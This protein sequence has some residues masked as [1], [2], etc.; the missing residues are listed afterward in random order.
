MMEQKIDYK[1]FYCSYLDDINHKLTDSNELRFGKKGSLSIN[2][3][4]GIWFDHQ[5]GEGGNPY[6]FLTQKQ[7]HTKQEALSLLNDDYKTFGHKP[8]KVLKQRGST[9]KQP[10]LAN[11]AKANQRKKTVEQR[12]NNEKLTEEE[13][14]KKEKSFKKFIVIHQE[15]RSL[16]ESKELQSYLL[17]RLICLNYLFE[18]ESLRE[19][20]NALIMGLN[21]NYYGLLVG[22]QLKKFDKQAD[23][24]L[25]TYFNNNY[26]KGFL[27][28][29]VLNWQNQPQTIGIC[30]GVETGLSIITMKE[31]NITMICCLTAGNVAKF[32]LD[33]KMLRGLREVTIYGD[34]DQAGKE[35]LESCYNYLL[36]AKKLF[37]LNLVI[38]FEYPPAEFNDFND[39]LLNKKMD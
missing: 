12:T 17:S 21:Q 30:E 39:I 28:F 24:R 7:G 10:I 4:N 6:Q 15:S 31:Q 27:F 11:E 19:L 29:T 8:K 22:Y 37:K 18:L 36:K 25:Q 33:L 38:N 20:N 32:N 35:A 3:K 26:Q 1:E 34:N 16:E 14:K 9:K 2:L 23:Y 13:K 5:S